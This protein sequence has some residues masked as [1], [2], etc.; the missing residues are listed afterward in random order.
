MTRRTAQNI[1]SS[2]HFVYFESDLQG[3]ILP[4]GKPDDEAVA[5]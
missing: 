3:W 4:L 1:T 2:R 5:L